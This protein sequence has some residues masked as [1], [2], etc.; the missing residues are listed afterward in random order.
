MTPDDVGGIPAPHRV[1]LRVVE[2]SDNP[3]DLLPV[4][5]AVVADFAPIDSICPQEGEIRMKT[6]FTQTPARGKRQPHDRDD[7]HD[8]GHTSTVETVLMNSLR[9]TMNLD[10]P[11]NRSCQQA[12]P[13]GTEGH[14]QQ[15]GVSADHG[16]YSGLGFA[17][18][19]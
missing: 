4:G 2:N 9:P 8:Q 19:A 6:N 14:I 16:A 11:P 1:P 3:R 17:D 5:H 18:E 10:Q 15:D 7:Q 12:Q 13:K